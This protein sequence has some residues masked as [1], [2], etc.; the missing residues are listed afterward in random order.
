MAERAAILCEH[1]LDISLQ[2]RQILIYL[3]LAT[4][5]STRP[6]IS[7]SA[8][9]TPSA[10]KQHRNSA[11]LRCL[12][13]MRGCQML[14]QVLVADASWNRRSSHKNSQ[15]CGSRRCLWNVEILAFPKTL[16][17][18]PLCRTPSHNLSLSLLGLGVLFEDRQPH[19]IIVAIA[20]VATAAVVCRRVHI[21]VDLGLLSLDSR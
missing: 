19:A 13:K 16:A 10:Q 21:C 1:F 20:T 2:Q 15:P 6:S 3:A 8:P 11:I 4:C 9:D 7:M 12:S 18:R 17:R 5:P 14:A